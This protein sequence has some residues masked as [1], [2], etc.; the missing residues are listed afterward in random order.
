[1]SCRAIAGAPARRRSID[2]LLRP[3]NSP[4]IGVW[5]AELLLS[6]SVSAAPS[7]LG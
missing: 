7:R 4:V 5:V 1:L 2:G 6:L 3:V